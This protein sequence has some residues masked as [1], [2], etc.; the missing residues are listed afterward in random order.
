MGDSK[1]GGGAPFDGF[2]D[3]F[4]GAEVEGL[5]L[6]AA[7]TAAKPPSSSS[8]SGFKYAS[9]INVRGRS[10]SGV[11]T[12]K[13]DAFEGLV[14]AFSGTGLGGGGGGEKDKRSSLFL[15]P[16]TGSTIQPPSRS[17][18]TGST[19][20][21][22]FSNSYFPTTATTT[23]GGVVT[24]S[25]HSPFATLPPLSPS[26]GHRYV[27]GLTPGPA[28]DI[29]AEVR[30]PSIEDF[31][32]TRTPSPM[33]SASK[34]VPNSSTT[35]SSSQ[36]TLAI[37]TRPH[38]VNRPSLTP[39]PS[40]SHVPD[41]MTGLGY[42]FPSNFDR[43]GARSQQTTGT[44]MKESA[45]GDR[46]FTALSSPTT[47]T[48]SG[49]PV[50]VASSESRYLSRRAS[51]T[52]NRKTSGGTM[53]EPVLPPRPAKADAT[54]GSVR[55]SASFKHAPLDW[56]TGDEPSSTSFDNSISLASPRVVSQI[57]VLQRRTSSSTPLAASSTGQKARTN[58]TGPV[59]PLPVMSKPPV[60]NGGG[61]GR[62]SRKPSMVASE[63][64]GDEGPEDAVVSRGGKKRAPQVTGGRG[65]LPDSGKP[66][67]GKSQLPDTSKPQGTVPPR[68]TAE[69]R[70]SVYD[71]VDLGGKPKSSTEARHGK[72]SSVYDL[73]DVKPP[74]SNSDATLEYTPRSG[75]SQFRFPT[76]SA[77]PSPD[78]PQPKRRPQSMFISPTSSAL[79][80]TK[81]TSVA[82]ES[83]ISESPTNAERPRRAP[84]RGSISDIV[85]KYEALGTGG[86]AKPTPPTTTTST[87]TTTTNT[88]TAS[89][90]GPPPPVASKPVGLKF[91]SNNQQPQQMMLAPVNLT[92]NS[93]HRR[94]P[95]MDV[96]MEMPVSPTKGLF[97]GTGRVSPR[98]VTFG[99]RLDVPAEAEEEKRSYGGNGG[100]SGSPVMMKRASPLMQPRAL[101]PPFPTDDLP[102]TKP[103]TPPPQSPS[104]D[105]P[106]Q[107]VGRLIDQWQKKA[108]EIKPPLSRGARPFGPRSGR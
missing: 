31:E 8:G 59:K 44:A 58:A 55:P 108:E 17:G 61:G 14:G 67:T 86:K 88:P 16:S 2:A 51:L 79:N 10:G 23:T 101:T 60:T 77:R 28:P 63:S 104:P 11:D 43:S 57:P 105:R 34:S 87:T 97:R 75:N 41:G 68:G 22:S 49:K 99:K 20:S 74:P 6:G 29:S 3:S 38:A 100:E 40:K 71:L 15:S 25:P 72:Q 35:T 18:S 33:M 39:Q 102:V 90:G 85:S 53:K 26:P 91:T 78:S 13:R 89:S 92:G 66:D 93:I 12:A 69:K 9:N 5:S 1:S 36:P 70:R 52:L 54:G 84:R 65:Q 45:R 106:Y 32:L 94:S 50:N 21:R 4:D 46:G 83:P 62:R 107:G 27:S 37:P 82:L 42:G 95:T 19:A 7:M 81:S 56:L 80:I 64:S 24:L 98:D 96:G 48:T 103:P 30:Y 76:N 73:V 47:E